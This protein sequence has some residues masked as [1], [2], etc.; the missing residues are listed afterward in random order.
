MQGSTQTGQLIVLGLKFVRCVLQAVLQ[1]LN[2]QLV[3]SQLGFRLHFQSHQILELLAEHT[4]YELLLGGRFG[5]ILQ[6]I[7]RPLAAFRLRLCRSNGD[8][9]RRRAAAARA[10]IL[11]GVRDKC[12]VQLGHFELSPPMRRLLL[13]QRN[14][15]L[16][17]ELVAIRLLL[18]IV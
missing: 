16:G 18:E 17:G 4:V 8:A 10:E 15:I 6:R 3:G 11:A 1:V 9:R 2:L 5:G 13:E 12:L 7:P 14:A